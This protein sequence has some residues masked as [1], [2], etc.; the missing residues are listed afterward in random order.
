MELVGSERSL[1]LDDHPF[2]G[3]ATDN[4]YRGM[5]D[6]MCRAV[7]GIEPWPRPPEQAV[8]VMRLLERI[9]AAG[10]EAVR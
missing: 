1:V 6:A 10:G 3:T 4:P 8:A 2:T 9:A 5:V 7:R